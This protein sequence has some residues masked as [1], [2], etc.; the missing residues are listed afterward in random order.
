MK[1]IIIKAIEELN[2][3]LP[4]KKK[5]LVKDSTPLVSESS[6]LESV[7]LVNL[8]VNLE[9]N[10]RKN[11][12]ILSFDDIVKN[13]DKFDTIGSLEIFLN[14]NFGNEKR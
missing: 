9:E 2:Q 11:N 5:I 7:D 14:N 8:F 3:L 4:E 6:E 13:A 1:Q 10:L 12:F